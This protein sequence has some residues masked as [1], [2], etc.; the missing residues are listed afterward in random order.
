MHETIRAFT[1]AA[2]E[3]AGTEA[4]QGSIAPGKF[5][6]LTLYDRDLFTIPADEVKETNIAG[7]MVD[8]EFKYQTW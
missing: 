3:T 6:D 7:T 8:G 5:A 1:L 2:A 4:R